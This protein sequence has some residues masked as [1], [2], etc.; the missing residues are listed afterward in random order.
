MI[1]RGETS[2]AQLCESAQRPNSAAMLRAALASLVAFASLLM[3]P[4]TANA[5]LQC[6][7][8]ARQIGDVQLSGNGR[9][10]WGNAA[11]VYARGQRPQAGAVLAFK[12]SGAMP[13]G[14][15]AVVSKVVD[16]RH[17]LINHANWSAP[18][19]IE[20][21]VEVVDISPAGDWS[22][23]RVWYGK[24]RSL[25]LRPSPTFGFIYPSLAPATVTASNDVATPAR[26]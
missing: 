22:Q 14:H 13:Y 15:V 12:A 2:R 11:G 3:M 19:L 17:I 10:W 21:G 20:R 16:D 18:G 8:Y 1:A 7:A 5:R 6:V 26:G 25:G 4:A 9:D 24:T 23:V